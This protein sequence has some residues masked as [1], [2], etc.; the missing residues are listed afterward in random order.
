M[1]FFIRN[2]G[3]CGGVVCASESKINIYYQ[4]MLMANNT[5]IDIGGSMYLYRTNVSF[6][7]K[8]S[9]I[10][11]NE[12]KAGGAI[13]AHESQLTFASGSGKLVGNKADDGGAIYARESKLIVEENS[14]MNLSSNL[15]LHNG[16]DLYLIMSKLNTKGYNLYFNENQANGNGGGIH[17]DN[18]SIIIEGEIHFIDNGTENG[19]AISLER[20]TKLLGKSDNNDTIN[21]ISNTASHQGGALYI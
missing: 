12:A 1:F 2:Q 9:T 15:V 14:R 13:F 20:Y 10:V 8:H 3:Y 17:A 16:R 19:G 7:S 5:A 21:L 18:S 6:L 4:I 11:S